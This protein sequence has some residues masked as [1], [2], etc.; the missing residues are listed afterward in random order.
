M[1]YLWGIDRELDR[2]RHP[3]RDHE[4]VGEAETRAH[5][6]AVTSGP[7]HREQIALHSRRKTAHGFVLLHVAAERWTRCCRALLRVHT[8]ANR[9]QCEN[10]GDD[11]QPRPVLSHSERS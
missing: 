1:N 10:N 5:V 7:G 2:D 8:H 4:N 3:V 9:D 11:D 6:G